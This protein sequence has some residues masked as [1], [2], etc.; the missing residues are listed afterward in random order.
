MLQLPLQQTSS[1][2]CKHLRCPCPDRPSLSTPLS[3]RAPAVLRAPGM[4]GRGTTHLCRNCSG[5]AV[6]TAETEAWN[7]RQRGHQSTEAQRNHHS[8]NHHHQRVQ[9]PSCS[10]QRCRTEAST[11]GGRGAPREQRTP[12]FHSTTHALQP[13]KF[14]DQ[15]SLGSYSLPSS[16]AQ[17]FPPWPLCL[18]AT[19]K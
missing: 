2:S 18:C 6:G 19:C 17:D 7:C 3:H 11:A 5:R 1:C 13:F 12:S 14:G 16:H 15:I 10:A 4:A 8:R 9:R